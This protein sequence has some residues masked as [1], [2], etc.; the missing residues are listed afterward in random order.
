MRYLK[1]LIIVSITILLAGCGSRSVLSTDQVPTST[2]N[3]E[4]IWDLQPKASLLGQVLPAKEYRLSFPM[5][6]IMTE[7]LVDEGDVVNPGDT[8]ARL[9]TSSLAFDLKKADVELASAL[10][11]QKKALSGPPP[12]QITLAALEVESARSGPQV[13]PKAEAT[14]RAEELSVAEARLKELMDQPYPEDIAVAQADVDQAQ[15]NLEKA[16]AQFENAVLKSQV[17]GNVI[18]VLIRENEYA[19][20]GQTVLIISD[21]S[22]LIVEAEMSD[23]DVADLQ[24]GDEALIS[25]EARPDLKVNGL[26]KDIRPS[27]GSTIGNFVVTISLIDPPPQV[28]WGMVAEIRFPNNK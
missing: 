8:I 7:L 28:R 1:S 13:L 24:I 5:P 9:D 26:I 21:L 23:A 25:F 3:V 15:A 11:R 19:N 2:I 16:K 18:Q 27:N 20:L 12:A 22:D 4:P 10:A 6:G 17:K 14:A